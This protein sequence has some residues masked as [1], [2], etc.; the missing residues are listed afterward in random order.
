MAY[1]DWTL[2]TVKK[3]FQLEA[4]NAAGIFAEVDPVEPSTHLATILH[5]IFLALSA[6]F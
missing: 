6:T 5:L 2:E 4:A 3:V 1:S